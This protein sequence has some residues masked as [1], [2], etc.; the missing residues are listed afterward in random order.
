[1]S[2]PLNLKR[3]REDLANGGQLFF[4]EVLR[5]PETGKPFLMLDAELWFL[6][7]A[8]KTD[9]NGRLLFPE[10]IYSAPKKSGKTM[11]AA[12]FVITLIVL[13]SE[14]FAEAYCC[15]NDLEQASSR[16]FEMCKRIIEASP[17]LKRSCK[18]TSDKITFSAT[19]AT[20]TALATDYASAAGGH[21][22]ISVFDELWAYTSERARR[23]WDEMVPVPTRRI[24]CR[25]TVSYAGFE[26]ESEL[27]YELYQ[28]A[29][30]Q[31][32]IGDDLYAGDGMLCFWTHKPVAH[33]QNEAWIEQMRRSLRA[34][35]FLRM[36]ENRFVS[37]ES[38]F[39]EMPTWDRCTDHKIGHAIADRTLPIWIGIDASVKHDSSA[40]VAVTFEHGRVKL[41]THRTFQPSPKNPLNFEQTI[42]A[43][44]LDLKK[45]YQ[46][47]KALF[48]P[49]Q[50][51]STAQR[52]AQQG[53]PVEEFAQSAPNL[54]AASQNLYELI[55]SAGLICYPDPA[56]RVAVSRCV[57]IETPRV[58]R[59][60][61]E[62]ASHKIDV[63]V[64]LAMAA[65]AC[66]QGQSEPAPYNTNYEEWVGGDPNDWH[67]WQFMNHIMAHAR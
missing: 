40:V 39:V 66:I 24:S 10:L 20:I 27:L 21:P 28:R 45:R 38:N 53:V 59:I 61:K 42:E 37:S 25:L 33:W 23:M 11:F 4:N 43:F 30:K 50:M 32:K 13:F 44:V 67:R 64:A 60:A 52:L 34:N 63:I 57:A 36:V 54:T 41:V 16:V 65:H 55:N 26:G 19:G 14:R 48:D 17:L 6:K 47:R 1:V 22:T 2:E 35:Q 18:V 5:N 49:Y 9:E 31:Q 56:M 51:Q 29:L 62:K 46:I 58:W 12:M 3:Y 15:A 7:L 8:L